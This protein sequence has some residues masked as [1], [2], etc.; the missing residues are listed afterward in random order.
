M[1]G[2]IRG[3]L[4]EVGESVVDGGVLGFERAQKAGE[5]GLRPLLRALT[6]D[7]A[8]RP[9]HGLLVHRVRI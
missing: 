5:G 7:A 1:C 3:V 8:Q 4:R 9:E 6:L 2:R